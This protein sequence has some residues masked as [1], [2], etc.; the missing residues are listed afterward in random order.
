MAS[1]SLVTLR[2]ADQTYSI[3]MQDLT[4][5]ELKLI[6]TLLPGG[7]VDGADLESAHGVVA[8]AFIAMKRKNPMVTIDEIDCLPVG[9]I[10]IVE[11]EDSVPPTSAD[12]DE[13]SGTPTSGDV[14]E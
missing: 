10:E 2:V 14:S 4:W 5:G 1:D 11:G 13:A 7:S 9:A 6:E 8:L 3:D 12:V